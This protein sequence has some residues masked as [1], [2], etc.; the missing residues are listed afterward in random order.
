MRRFRWRHHARVITASQPATVW[1]RVNPAPFLS[2]FRGSMLGRVITDL[3]EIRRLGETKRVENLHFRRFLAAHH[4]P[5]E[6]FQ[7]LAA[8]VQE[9][10]DCTACANCCRYSVVTL[11][12][13]EIESIARRLGLTVSEA[14]HRYTDADPDSHHTRIL[15]TTA[16]GCVFL[17]G[18]LCSIY[19]VRPSV[20]RNFPHL[21]P[22]D[23]SL[24][25]RLSSLCRWAEACPIVYNALEGYKRIVGYHPRRQ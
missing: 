3:L 1:M 11:T 13:T 22:G 25:S 7:I 20:C 17:K 8:H 6:P 15:R 16:R 9:Q 12:P 19:D 5:I 24:G 18:N 23:H 2:G 10:T 21:L 14:E 4:V